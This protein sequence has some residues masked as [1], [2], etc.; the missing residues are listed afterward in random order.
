MESAMRASV[1]MFRRIVSLVVV[2]AALSCG[3]ANRGQAPTH[4]TRIKDSAPEQIAAQRAASRRID[5]ELDDDRMELDAAREH[6]RRQEER[7]RPP[8]EWSPPADLRRVRGEKV[9]K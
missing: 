4:S 3:T 2:S 7:R 5:P 9:A 8:T 1:R 6:K